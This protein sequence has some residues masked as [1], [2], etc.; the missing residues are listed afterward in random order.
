MT[1]RWTLGRGLFRLWLIA[2]LAWIIA[3]WVLLVTAPITWPWSGPP[4]VHALDKDYPL[5]WGEDRIRAAIKQDI[6]NAQAKRR[7]ASV[8]RADCESDFTKADAERSGW[9]DALQPTLDEMEA[10]LLPHRAFWAPI[11]A[12]NVAVVLWPFEV[13]PPLAVFLA[14]CL[15]LWVIRGFRRRA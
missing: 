9:C 6:A 2:S 11:K 13:L 3:V 14:G 1:T 7:A 12:V 4:V 5:A 15:L 8:H 10:E